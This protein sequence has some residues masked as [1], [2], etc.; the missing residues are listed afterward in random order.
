MAR[1]G[2]SRGPEGMA[3]GR[4]GFC[5]VGTGVRVGWVRLRGTAVFSV[6][7]ALGSKPALE[8]PSEHQAY[9]L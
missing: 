2:G 3:Y 7:M 1:A 4:A 9:L 6:H 8:E 5:T